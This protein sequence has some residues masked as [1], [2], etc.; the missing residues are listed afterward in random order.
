MTQLSRCSPL[1]D[2]GYTLVEALA[3]LTIIALIAAIA[4]PKLMG[5]SEHWRLQA[6][7]RD[8]I[9]ALRLTRSSAVAHNTA[10]VVE[11]NVD[12][13]T[14]RS[15]VVPVRRFPSEIDIDMR[16]AESEHITPSI[17]GFR[18][19]PDGSSTGGDLTLALHGKHIAICVPW[20]TGQ[21]RLAGGC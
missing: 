14:V 13:R 7:A 1:V 11:I 6:A 20:L 21:P 18:F 4:F 16:V 2:D 5:S 9:S 15:P 10:I 12:Q 8:I 17:G 19:F 3:V